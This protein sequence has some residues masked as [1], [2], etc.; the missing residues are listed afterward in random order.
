MGFLVGKSASGGAPTD[1]GI[2][3]GCSCD[4]YSF[5]FFFGSTSTFF[6]LFVPVRDVRCVSTLQRV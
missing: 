5:F 2:G 3:Q 1:G 6:F 4:C